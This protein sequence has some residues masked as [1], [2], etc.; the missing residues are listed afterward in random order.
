MVIKQQSSPVSITPRHHTHK[1]TYSWTYTHVQLHIQ[2]FTCTYT[3]THIHTY[4]LRHPNFQGF[5]N[6]L[7]QTELCIRGVWGCFK[8][9][10]WVTRDL[11]KQ[12]SWESANPCCNN[13]SGNITY[14]I[15]LFLTF[16]KILISFPPKI[17]HF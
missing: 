17:P 13:N 9:H 14:F 3:H 1:P 8:K 6:S 7:F 4:K 10:F 16:S 11:H 2:D 15:L 5:V 12:T